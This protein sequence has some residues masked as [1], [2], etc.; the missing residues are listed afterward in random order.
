MT[1]NLRNKLYIIRWAEN[2]DIVHGWSF[3]N[4]E[5]ALKTIK[6]FEE[7]DKL[8][9]CYTANTYEVVK[10]Q[11]ESEVKLTIRSVEVLDVY[12]SDGNKLY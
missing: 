8:N 5:D 7:E 11:L 1:S 10:V 3:Y 12:D 4:L 6:D 2:G 9:E